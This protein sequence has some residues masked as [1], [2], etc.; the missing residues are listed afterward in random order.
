MNCQCFQVPSYG[1]DSGSGPELDGYRAHVAARAD[2]FRGDG[3]PRRQGEPAPLRGLF[4]LLPMG[5]ALL[6]VLLLWTLAGV[7]LTTDAALKV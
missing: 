7:V 5:L 2:D 3:F 1:A 6:G 4:P